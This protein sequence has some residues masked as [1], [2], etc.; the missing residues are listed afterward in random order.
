MKKL[1]IIAAL[2]FMAA[3]MAQAQPQSPKIFEARHQTIEK[4]EFSQERSYSEKPDFRQ[5]VS[6]MDKLSK[7]D[8]QSSQE[9]KDSQ[10]AQKKQLTRDFAD[11]EYLNYRADRAVQQ[12]YE[13]GLKYY[14]ILRLKEATAQKEDSER[15]LY[16]LTLRQAREKEEL[17]KKFAKALSDGRDY[18]KYGVELRKLEEKHAKQIAKAQKNFSKAM[19]V[20]ENAVQGFVR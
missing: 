2:Y 16:E 3:S 14:A 15:K 19:D 4:A 7:R 13:L 11:Q 12:E 18:E 10:V 17:R 1:F 6:D 5:K 20:Y 9:R 8:T